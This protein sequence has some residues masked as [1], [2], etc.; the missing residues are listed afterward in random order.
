MINQYSAGKT[1][2]RIIMDMVNMNIIIGFNKL[3]YSSDD[4]QPSSMSVKP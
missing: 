3:V 1:Y 2:G 4:L